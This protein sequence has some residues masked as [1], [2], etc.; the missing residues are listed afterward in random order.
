MI[1]RIDHVSIAV[2]DEKS[3]RHF[4]Q[5]VLGAVSG[6]GDED[7]DMKFDWR[8]YSLGDLSRL[9]ILTPMGNGSFLDNFLK[10]KKGGVHHITLQT[11][12][13]DQAKRT[14]DAHGVPYFGDNEYEDFYWK[15]IFIHP[16]DAFGVLIQIAEFNPDDWLDASVKLSGKRKW[17]LKKV[18]KTYTLCFRHP[19]GG[20]VKYNLA[21]EEIVELIH[22]LNSVL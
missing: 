12:D 14:L 2:G 11:P 20:T 5:N 4:F 8:I 13:I 7:R 1:S 22:D 19:G 9:E 21:K 3:A 6:F 17:S 18:G 10:K 16:K 15:E